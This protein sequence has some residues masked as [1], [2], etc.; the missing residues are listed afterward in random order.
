[1]NKR[2]I[3]DGNSTGSM[4]YWTDRFSLFFHLIKEKLGFDIR[5]AVTYSDFKRMTAGVDLILAF[6][7]EQR[8]RRH[9]EGL[10]TLNKN[11]KFILYMHDVHWAKIKRNEGTTKLLTR[12]DLIMVPY[13][14]YFKKV[15]PQ[16]V[17]KTI[18]F[19]HFFASQNRYCNLKYNDNPKMKCLLTGN[20]KQDRYPIRW[21]VQRTAEKNSEVKSLIDILRHPRHSKTQYW[22]RKEGGQKQQYAKTVHE[23]FCSVA[24]ASKWH[25]L[26]TKYFE[27]PATGALLLADE[28]QDGRRTGLIPG[29]HYI[30]VTKDN[31]LDQIKDCLK[32]PGNYE[33]IRKRGMEF[34]RANHGI[35]NRLGQF[36]RI[37]ERVI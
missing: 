4:L 27:I 6:A 9:M 26:L 33:K 20:I 35:N 24:D 14:T 37:L 25:L 10:I 18:F 16:F 29:E 36:K 21:V 17:D 13:Y 32:N 30:E 15:W 23:Y 22:T 19:P 5:P 34:V 2:I 3:V 11:V 1:M 31:V 7:C 28:P 8:P 12:A